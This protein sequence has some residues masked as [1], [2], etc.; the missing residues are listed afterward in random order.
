MAE[1][2]GELV[3]E[4]GLARTTGARNEDDGAGATEREQFAGEL[5]G[6]CK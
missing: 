3:Q 1:Q 4:E 2:V 6:G 5:G